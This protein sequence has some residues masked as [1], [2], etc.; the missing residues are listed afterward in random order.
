MAHERVYVLT[1]RVGGR[2]VGGKTDSELSP[3]TREILDL[4]VATGRAILESVSL[5]NWKSV[6]REEMP[7]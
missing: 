2:G 4:R 1:Y 6:E 7:Q 5:V 3:S